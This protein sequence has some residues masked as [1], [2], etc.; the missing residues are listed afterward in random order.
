M[1]NADDPAV[2]G[3]RLSLLKDIDEVFMAFADFS[4]IVVQGS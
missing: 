3:N 1:V 4:Q 2:R